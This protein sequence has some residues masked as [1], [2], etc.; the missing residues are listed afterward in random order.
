[1]AAEHSREMSRTAEQGALTHRQIMFIFGAL[2]LAMLLAALDQTIVSTALPTIVGDLGGLSQLS[3]VV[4]AY[5]LTSTVSSPIYGKIGD[6]Y[7]RKSIFQAAIVIFLIGSALSGLSQNMAELIGFRAIQ[8]LGAGGL[9]V[10]AQSIIAD[11]V[12]PRERGRYQGYF[13]AVFGISTVVGPLIG[14]FFVDHL[15]WR[16][17]FY[18]NLPVGIAALIVTGLVLHLPVHRL[19]H[20]IDYEGAAL[21]AA[22][23]ACLVLLTTWGGTQYA[24]NSPEIIGLGIA[25]V[26][27]LAIF[28]VQ[29]TRASE[30]IIPLGLFRNSVFSLTGAI[31]FIVGFG[32]FGSIIFLPQYMQ[33]VRGES[34]TNSGLLLLPVM[35]GVLVA[36]IGSGQLISKY[37][38]YKPYPIIGTALTAIGLFLL[39]RLGTS[40]SHLV[41]SLYMVILGLGLGLVMQVLVLAVQ[42][43]VDYRDLGT[44]TSV[45]TFFRSIGGSFGVA[46]FGSIFT[47]TLQTNLAKAL[48]SG[49]G[50]LALSGGHASPAAVAKLPPAL[51]TPIIHAYSQSL[52]SVFLSGVPI[53]IAAF[54]LAWFLREV[55]LRERAGL[56]QGMDETFGMQ[57]VGHAEICEELNM[58]R[59]AAQVAL[60]RLETVDAGDVPAP[61]IEGL[62]RR[63]QERIDQLE[64]YGQLLEGEQVEQSPEFRRVVLEL[65]Q[66]ERTEMER[67]AEGDGVTPAVADR[68]IR[69]LQVSDGGTKSRSA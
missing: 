26:V 67:L 18:V 17:V 48:P 2:M 40:T 27:L 58:R 41:S 21:L 61:L 44:A 37:G 52:D 24:W 62:R 51:H 36:S 42:N 14:G 46:I 9:M 30:P 35:A 63:Y 19:Q 57:D 3:W 8:G 64:E 1:V 25:G 28:V 15:S 59:Q 20:R 16:W 56:M 55:P 11:V 69:D 10:G 66:T 22:G 23:V 65:L 47:N 39:S 54:V 34:A 45:S 7:G 31:G 50:A 6:L 60:Q 32:M 68:A 53:L 33:V 5:I 38:H 43:A 12:S 49:K 4:T 29:E 13:G